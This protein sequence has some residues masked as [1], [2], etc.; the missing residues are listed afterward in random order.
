MAAQRPPA[1]PSTGHGRDRARGRSRSRERDG[2]HKK[3]PSGWDRQDTGGAAAGRSGWGDSSKPSAG[4]NETG[5]EQSW[6]EESR[7]EIERQRERERRE[8][9]QARA[10]TAPHCNLN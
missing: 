8:E 7:L 9:E 2:E 3:A 4:S 6:E 1:H 5:Q 10:M